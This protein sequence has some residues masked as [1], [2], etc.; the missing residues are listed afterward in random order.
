[1]RSGEAGASAGSGTPLPLAISVASAAGCGTSKADEPPHAKLTR[2][3][4]LDPHSCASCHPDH[5]REWSGSMHAY[6][7]VDP[8]FIAL[9]RRMQRETNGALGSFCVQCHAPVAMRTG[10]TKDGLN[11]N[12]LEPKTRGVT[13]YF[14]H[15][16]EFISGEFSNNPLVLFDDGR[17]RGGFDNPVPNVAH[18][19]QYSRFADHGNDSSATFCSSCHDIV[20]PKGAHIARTFAEWRRSHF[21]LEERTKCGECHM[22]ER[23]GLAAQAPGVLVRKVHDHSMPGVD[24]ALTPFPEAD[25]QRAAVQRS[26]DSAISAQ[27]CVTEDAAAGSVKVEVTLRNEKVDHSW[28]SGSAQDR[29]AWVE[30]EGSL[31]GVAVFGSGKVPDRTAVAA[32]A[33]AQVMLLR[34][35]DYDAD[36]RE[37]RLFWKTARFDSVTLP[38]AHTSGGP[39][40]ERSLVHA[41][42]FAGPMPDRVEMRVK[43]RPVDFDLV[44]DLV[45]CRATVTPPHRVASRTDATRR[46]HTKSHSPPSSIHHCHG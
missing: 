32:A 35:Y 4:L 16:S 25:A 26:L 33:D 39:D 5:V 30:L 42:A 36:G 2:E 23:T 1:M 19:A 41:Y 8:L 15:N 20:N 43:I 28:P 14:C 17:M 29:R 22:N 27:P 9:N 45:A 6:A 37:T 31:G 21:A 7:G 13:C 11:L 44:D 10:L 40:S 24:L 38:V 3:A 34:D 46:P 12:E 18:E